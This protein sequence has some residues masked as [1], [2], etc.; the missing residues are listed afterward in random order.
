MASLLDMQDRMA[1]EEY[2][3]RRIVETN[4]KFQVRCDADLARL[5]E[6]PPEEITSQTREHVPVRRGRRPQ[7]DPRPK[8]RIGRLR[9]KLNSRDARFRTDVFTVRQALREVYRNVSFEDFVTLI[10]FVLRGLKL[11]KHY[12]PLERITYWHAEDPSFR[13]AVAS[14]TYPRQLLL[15]MGFI[16]V[17]GIYWV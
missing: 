4:T 6:L 5:M 14:N 16:C 11:I 9:N 8:S 13:H 15:Q 3:A 2:S 10:N 17:N 1:E 7:P 12:N